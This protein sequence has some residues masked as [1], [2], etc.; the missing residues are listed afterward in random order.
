MCRRGR[1]TH[2]IRGN[3][4]H[5]ASLTVKKT[6]SGRLH[7]AVSGIAGGTAVCS[8]RNGRKPADPLNPLNRVNRH[9]RNRTA[10]FFPIRIELFAASHFIG[11]LRVRKPDISQSAALHKAVR[12]FKMRQ[13]ID[14]EHAAKADILL[15]FIMKN[16]VSIGI[17]QFYKRRH[18]RRHGLLAEHAYAMCQRKG[19]NL[20][21]SR[22][23]RVDNRDIRRRSKKHFPPIPIN[24]RR[25][26]IC[27]KLPLCT[28]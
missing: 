6:E 16:R 5:P 13:I 8:H 22:H 18:I 1:R 26:S 3:G 25:K 15:I 24:A 23:H 28:V 21:I 20:G 27:R 12:C 10:V 7:R 17:L 9:P 11:F 14:S 19:G 2:N 4:S